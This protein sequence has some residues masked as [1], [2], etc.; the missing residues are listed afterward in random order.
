M[1]QIT[2]NDDIYVEYLMKQA[3]ELVVEST[4]EMIE[5]SYRLKMYQA[6]NL[7]IDI[8]KYQEEKIKKLEGYQDMN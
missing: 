8:I 5:A 1:I 2:I 3:Y 6:I 7:L 4:K